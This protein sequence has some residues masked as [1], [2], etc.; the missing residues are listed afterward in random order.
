MQDYTFRWLDGRRLGE[1][2]PNRTWGY[3]LN[4]EGIAIG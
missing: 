2:N 1:P 3:D 4:S